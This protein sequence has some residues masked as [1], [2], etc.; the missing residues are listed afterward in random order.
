MSDGYL[1]YRMRGAPLYNFPWS[2][3]VTAALRAQGH[4]VW[5]PAEHDESNGFDPAV[6][7][8]KPL[9]FYMEHDLAEV[10]KRPAIFLGRDWGQSV[11]ACLEAFT[12]CVLG[13]DIFEVTESRGSC[14]D[15]NELSV[16]LL[17]RDP[18][19]VMGRAY[20]RLLPEVLGQ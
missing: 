1:A 15:E 2:H 14:R 10:C 19:V 9:A 4:D 12:A 5:N 18:T 6:S 7:E 11:G 20:Q 17:R 3:E 8:P 16:G 13:K